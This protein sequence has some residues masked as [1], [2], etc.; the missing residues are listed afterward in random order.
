MK[1]IEDKNMTE[2]LGPGIPKEKLQEI[3]SKV[4]QGA[5]PT[6]DIPPQATEKTPVMEI[7]ESLSKL[8]IGEQR[9]LLPSVGEF[10]QCKSAL[11]KPLRGV[12][13]E[14]LLTAQEN[15]S[16][17][18]LAK[19]VPALFQATEKFKQTKWPVI[20]EKDLLLDILSLTKFAT[21][22]SGPM[23]VEDLTIPDFLCLTLYLY[24]LTYGAKFKFECSEGH[25]YTAKLNEIE[26]L[27][28]DSQILSPV[29]MKRSDEDLRFHF[30]DKKL[31]AV[32]IA[33]MP[34]GT[35]FYWRIP[36]VKDHFYLSHDL[37]TWSLILL[38][39][40]IEVNGKPLNID[41]Q[42]IISVIS[43]LNPE[44]FNRIYS[45]LLGLAYGKL[46][47]FYYGVNEEKVITVQCPQ[48]EKSVV[49]TSIGRLRSVMT[50][51]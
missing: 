14:L 44:L 16:T 48:H 43:A 10:Y 41:A 29:L 37:P 47:E 25:Q 39:S 30:S 27:T 8:N 38:F 22:E 46:D 45:V 1:I 20:D 42:Y 3:V 24:L 49:R 50:L 4:T 15:L 36:R 28:F 51:V 33:N 26:L 5:K 13:Q 34:P 35:K 9:V 31:L 18:D 23:E 21:W 19:G 17:I 2:D 7:L 12:D 6:T 40:H 32:E 11:V